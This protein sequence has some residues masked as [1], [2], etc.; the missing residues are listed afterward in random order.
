M[1]LGKIDYL[2]LLPFHVFLKASRLQNATKKSIELK[3]GTPSK[4]CDDLRARRIDA[5]VISSIEARRYKQLNFGICA[6]G[7]VSSVLVEKGSKSQKDAQSRSSNMLAKVLGIKGKVLI[8]DKALKAYL[9]APQ[10]FYDLA[11][12]WEQKTALPFVFG[13][14]ACVKNKKAYKK[15]IKAF[16]NK[17]IKIPRYILNSYSQS[18]QISQ[19]DILEYLKLIYYKIGK[20]E[21]KALTI[22]ISRSRSLHFKA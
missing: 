14:F 5:G 9:K 15:I 3:K 17:N 18:R 6:K 2:N 11:N 19:N 4:L 1:I 21:Q 7:R 10:D 8:G 12:L 13:R 16:L 22:F 20:K